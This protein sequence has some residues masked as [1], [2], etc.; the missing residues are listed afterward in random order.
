M[1][2]NSPQDPPGKIRAITSRDPDDPRSPFHDLSGKQMNPFAR[3][4][5]RRQKI[6]PKTCDDSLQTSDSSHEILIAENTEDSLVK[7]PECAVTEWTSWSDCSVACGKGLRMRKRSYLMP[8]KALMNQCDRQL[9]E[10]EMCLGQVPIC[11]NEADQIEELDK[12]C[13]VSEWSDWSP[14]SVTCGK[15]THT[16]SRA[17]KDSMGR[18]KCNLE[19]RQS[20]S[21]VG[22]LE[23]CNS[24]EDMIKPD[25][26]CA[27][28]PWSEWSPCSVTCGKGFRQRTR[29][30]MSDDVPRK[31]HSIQTMEKIEC[32]GTAGLDCEIS[33][34]EAK[35]ICML[36][37]ETGSCRG[38]KPRFS[39]NIEKGMCVPFVYGGCKG[40]RNRFETEADCLKVCGFLANNQPLITSS[41]T[42]DENVLSPEPLPVTRTRHEGSSTSPE[43]HPVV[44][45]ENG[46]EDN[47]SQRVDCVVSE[48]SAWS[49]CS[50]TCG[51][52]QSI[53]SRTILVEPRNGGRKCR[54]LKRRRNCIAPC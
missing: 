38:H 23:E 11:E 20:K 26:D 22:V 28:T 7:R 43:D 25:P 12:V 31:C 36:P 29:L 8:A 19:T 45:P 39:F 30:F 24:V 32:N 54:R 5:I 49:P 51:A 6:Y 3:A 1:S 4:H 37:A 44:E 21:C 50:V 34:A 48:W 16:R 14:C 41:S 42:V 52:G 47:G 2:P 10:K 35:E 15:G 17:Y 27:L 13:A 40:N 9:V 18:K 46:T 33:M 53:K